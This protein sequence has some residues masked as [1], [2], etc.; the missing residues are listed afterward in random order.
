MSRSVLRAAVVA[1]ASIALV[2]ASVTPLL[3]AECC[4]GGGCCPG[5]NAQRVPTIRPTCCCP[6]IAPAPRPARSSAPVAAPASPVP[7]A[8]PAVALVPPGLSGL[9]GP[10]R[11]PAS[12]RGGPDPPP[13]FLLTL[14]IRR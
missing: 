6:E 7:D 8:A 4:G 3:A 11:P 9:I 1:V 13:I 5:R 12:P 10:T 2:A 14:S